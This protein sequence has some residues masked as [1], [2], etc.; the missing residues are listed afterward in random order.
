MESSQLHIIMPIYN[1]AATLPRAVGS[2]RCI[3]AR[4]RHRIHLIGVDDGSTDDS[5]MIFKRVAAEVQG[6]QWTFLHR[7]NG[8]SGAARNEALRSFSAGWTLCLDADDELVSD[9][10]PFLDQTPEATALLFDADFQR[11]EKSLFS[12]PARRPDNKMLPQIFSARN[13]FHPLSIVFRREL[14]DYFFAEDLRFLEDWHFLA[15]NP[16][17]FARCTVYRGVAIGRVH[18]SK[19]SKSADQYKNGY[20]R[21]AVAE[22]LAKYW[23]DEKS[24][25]VRNNLAIQKA[26]GKIQMGE[27]APLTTVLLL[28]ATISLYAKLWI[29]LFAYRL[30]LRFYP[31]A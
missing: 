21:V 28:P 15:T 31:Y 4:H 14:L 26:I 1:A 3:A 24:L 22:R 9:P 23:A 2:L 25:I 18:G 19:Q 29:Y 13:P 12:M 11:E 8:G 16:R 7:E 6:L 30:Y 10:I 17:F 27:S 5:A 20:Y